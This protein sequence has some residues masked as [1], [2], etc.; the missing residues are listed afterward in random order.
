MSLTCRHVLQSTATAKHTTPH[1][2]RNT[3]ESK[4]TTEATM[5]I[6]QVITQI[7]SWSLTSLFSTNMATSETN[8]HSL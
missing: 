8:G 6:I 3:K 7:V 5:P 1:E 4:L 2:N